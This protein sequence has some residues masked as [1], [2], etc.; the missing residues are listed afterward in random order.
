MTKTLLLPACFGP[1]QYFACLYNMPAIIEKHANYTRQTYRNRYVIMGPNGP[2]TLSV[3][4]EKDPRQKVPDKDVKIAYHTPW[5]KIHWRSLVS[6]YNSSPYFQYYRDEIETFIFEKHTYLF[7]FDV[8]STEL[9]TELLGFEPDISVTDEYMMDP[10]NNII[11]MRDIIHPKRD[12]DKETSIFK[13]H[14]YKQVF[15]DR[16]GFVPHL[17]MLDLLF[18]KGPESQFILDQSINKTDG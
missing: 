6:A 2:I 10:N 9:V 18:N 14:P 4:I 17:S 15:D 12:I 1:V 16:H 7:E 11:D 8:K 3:P 5:Q 13:I